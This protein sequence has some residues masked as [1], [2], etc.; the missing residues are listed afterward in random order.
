MDTAII[1]HA[2]C[3]F[4]TFTTFDDTLAYDMERIFWSESVVGEYLKDAQLMQ[5]S[6][7]RFDHGFMGE[8][9]QQERK[10]HLA[11]VS[12]R[13]AHE[14]ARAIA[15]R[16]ACAEYRCTRF[17]AQVTIGIPEGYNARSF[18][19]WLRANDTRNR[20]ILL[21]ENGDGLDTVY[22]G[23]KTSD[24]FTR[25]YVKVIAGVRH[26]RYE[27][28]RRG[29]YA[30]QAWS[31]VCET[32]NVSEA[33]RR[34]LVNAFMGVTESPII[35]HAQSYVGDE[36]NMTGEIVHGHG[37][38]EDWLSSV[39]TGTLVKYASRGDGERSFAKSLLDRAH[40]AIR[41]LGDSKP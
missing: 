11:T 10:H 29:E 4:I 28:Q 25:I 8:G 26:L 31:T 16:D 19:D 17:D 23:S 15:R 1:N 36:G 9:V 22:I 39:V 2:M 5:Y 27:T 6:G 21:Y 32:G 37:K 41:Q 38:T 20:K 34:T 12:G 14:F 24:S 7:W 3:D 30:R 18:A 33:C 35:R 13:Q 40:R